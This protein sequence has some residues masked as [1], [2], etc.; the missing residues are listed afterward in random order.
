MEFKSFMI[1]AINSPLYPIEPHKFR[2][3]ML[4]NSSTVVP[5]FAMYIQ[6][7]I[8]KYISSISKCA[9]I[10]PH[11]FR[12]PQVT[13]II[14]KSFNRFENK[15][16]VSLSLQFSHYIGRM[17]FVIYH[18]IRRNAKATQGVYSIQILL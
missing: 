3:L 7:I 1:I 18:D 11:P 4:L 15:S 12:L 14:F 13:I 17:L 6:T 5:T 2:V 9:V 16:V 10:H 8:I